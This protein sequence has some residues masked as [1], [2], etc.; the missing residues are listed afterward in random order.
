MHAA[1]YWLIGKASSFDDDAEI[2]S[3]YDY[4]SR[5]VLVLAYLTRSNTLGQAAR[6]HRHL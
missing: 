5:A 4:T 1:A 6:P 3:C 2:D